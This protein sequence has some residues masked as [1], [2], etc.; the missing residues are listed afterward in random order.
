MDTAMQPSAYPP[1]S[2][3]PPDKVVNLVKTKAGA[4]TSSTVIIPLRQK[5]PCQS[6]FSPT[7]TPT[8]KNPIKSP[9]QYFQICY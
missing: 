9:S 2:G 8:Y 3:P 7:N 1:A 4:G 6:P 5:S